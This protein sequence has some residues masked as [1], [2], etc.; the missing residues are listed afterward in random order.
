MTLENF[1]STAT[2]QLS[3]GPGAY[4]VDADRTI[5]G[6][7]SLRFRVNAMERPLARASRTLTSDVDFP[8]T[9]THS[10]LGRRGKSI[11]PYYPIRR[12]TGNELGPS[13]VPDLNDGF[14]RSVVIK[15]RY[16]DRDAARTPGPGQYDPR[17][18][19][20]TNYPPMGPRPPITLSS[21][22]CSPGPG[23]YEI[24]R[25]LG[26][27]PLRYSIGGVDPP[28]ER[29]PGYEDGDPHTPGLDAPPAVA[30]GGPGYKYNNPRNSDTRPP[31]WS[32]IM[33]G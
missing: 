11:G 9:D 3:P 24:S 4:D 18:W 13:Y 5:G 17:E 27:H 23:H 21:P 33:V 32:L 6:P 14:R 2:A 10:T 22:T 30:G 29:A 26:D 28:S 8:P 1:S 31:R 7:R 20:K 25:D 19:P 16:P 12:A 15:A